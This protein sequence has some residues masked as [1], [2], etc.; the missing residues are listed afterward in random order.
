MLTTTYFF[1]QYIT[2]YLLE[3]FRRMKDIFFLYY[4]DFMGKDL[5]SWLEYRMC[6]I[7]KRGTKLF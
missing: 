1:I 7:I 4:D 5:S 6:E 2:E 3:M